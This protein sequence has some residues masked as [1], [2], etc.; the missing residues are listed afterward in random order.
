MSS[1]PFEFFFFGGFV[2]AGLS[3]GIAYLMLASFRTVRNEYLLGYPIGF[4]LVGFSYALFGLSYLMPFLGNITSWLY[5]IL[6]CYGFAFLAFTYLFRKSSVTSV[7]RGPRLWYFLLVIFAIGVVLAVFPSMS[8][9][10]SFQD[11]DG[12]FRVVNLLFIG[13]IIY[14]LNQ[15]LKAQAELSSVVLG[16]TFLAIEQCSLL[17]WALDQRFVWALLFAQLVRIV[18]LAILVTFIVKGFGRQ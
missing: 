17:L 12:F 7:T 1:L 13:Y 4:S 10:P 5:L 9:L 2:S 14:S 8:F 16:F 11:A 3:F 6:G 15:A 18:G